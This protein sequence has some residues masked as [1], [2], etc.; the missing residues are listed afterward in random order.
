L[1]ISIFDSDI[2]LFYRGDRPLKSIS[3]LLQNE[4]KN[5][6]TLTANISRLKII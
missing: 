3:T 1:D 6:D 5:G 4:I 2:D